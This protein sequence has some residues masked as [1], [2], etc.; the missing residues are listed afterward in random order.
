MELDV[1]SAF[2][3]SIGRMRIPDADA[4]NRGLRALILAEEANTQVWV[5]AISEVDGAGLTEPPEDLKSHVET[6]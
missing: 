4:M 6:R 2:P 5:V 3:T 1:T